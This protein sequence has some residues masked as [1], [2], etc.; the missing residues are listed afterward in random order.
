MVSFHDFALLYKKSQIPG[1][2]LSVVPK[3]KHKHLYPTSFEK[4]NVK[5][6]AQILSQSVANGFKYFRTQSNEEDKQQ[7]A[8]N[9]ALFRFFF[10]IFYFGLRLLIYFNSH[11]IDTK[12]IEEMVLL[13]NDCFAIMNGR[14]RVKAVTK[15]SWEK[16]DKAVYI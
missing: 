3:L 15:R 13:I 11:L 7:F 10:F 16:R 4:M 6:A 1:T 9:N 2:P 5:L 14:C 12:A 8:R